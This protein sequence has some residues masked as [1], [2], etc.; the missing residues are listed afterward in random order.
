MFLGGNQPLAIL[1][2]DNWDAPKLLV[3]RDSYFDSM[4]PFLTPHYSEIYI[5]DFRYNR[6]DVSQFMEETGIDEVFICY[7]LANFHQDAN[8]GLVLK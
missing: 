6:A 2:T 8:F 7:S 1:R 5:V 3:I 4:A